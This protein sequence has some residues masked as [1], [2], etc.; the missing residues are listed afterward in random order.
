[1]ANHFM[2]NLEKWNE[3]PKNY[4]AIFTAAAGFT[5]RQ[6]RYP[7]SR[8]IEATRRGGHASASLLAGHHGGL[9]EGITRGER[10][11]VGDQPGLQEGMGLHRTIPH[12]R[13]FWWQVAEFGYDNFMIRTGM[14]T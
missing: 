11:N 13:V 10:G 8:S 6:V 14:K 5:N 4:Q 1:T 3:L 7:K 2:I 12:R 9:P